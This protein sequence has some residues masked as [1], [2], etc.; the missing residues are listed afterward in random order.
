M[1]DSAFACHGDF[2][3]CG[4]HCGKAGEMVEPSPEMPDFYGFQA[5][6]KPVNG[7]FSG[8]GGCHALSAPA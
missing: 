4:K 7:D 3:T 5:W 6:R 8:F 2:H 1:L